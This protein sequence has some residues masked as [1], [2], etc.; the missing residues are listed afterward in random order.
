MPRPKREKELRDGRLN[1][2]ARRLWL[3]V[4]SSEKI[5]MSERLDA[6]DMAA[7]RFLSKWAKEDGE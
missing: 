6:A 1:E 4:V 3:A 2:E 5:P 7:D